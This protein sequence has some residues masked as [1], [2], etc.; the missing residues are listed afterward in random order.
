MNAWGVDGVPAAVVVS[1]C[2]RASPKTLL[3][4]DPLATKFGAKSERESGTKNWTHFEWKTLYG[5]REWY[6]QC[7]CQST[8]KLAAC[9]VKNILY[10]LITTWT[11]VGSPIPF[12]CIKYSLHFVQY[13]KVQAGSTV[14]MGSGNIITGQISHMQAEVAVPHEKEHK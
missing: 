12:P 9:S 2:C 6:R 10:I 11:T 14:D 8:I 7:T 3:Q 4:T 13:F 1:H 5:G